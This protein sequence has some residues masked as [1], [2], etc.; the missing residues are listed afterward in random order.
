[1]TW[2][3][4]KNSRQNANMVISLAKGKKQKE[5]SSDLNNPNHQ[6]EI[7]RVAK[8]MVKERQ[9]IMDLHCLNG[10]SDKVIVDKT[11]I[12]YSRKEYTV[13]LM[14]EEN[15]WDH[16]ISAGVKQGLTDC[17]SV[18]EVGAALKKDEKT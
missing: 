11:G 2:K 9:D 6:N 7:S 5:C 13:K 4:Y 1:V 8:Q 17:I 15:D 10:V 12:K 16:R 3:K 18:H 14:N